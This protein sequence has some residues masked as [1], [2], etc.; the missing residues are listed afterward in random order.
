MYKFIS[1]RN[2]RED[3]T[4]CEEEC[5]NIEEECIAFRSLFQRQLRFGPETFMLNKEQKFIV[6]KYIIFYE[7]TCISH[8]I[9]L[10]QS[11]EIKGQ[12]VEERGGGEI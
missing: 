12:A 10:L 8:K 4:F 2:N 9:L 7:I 5:D 6:V 11:D 3:T 1:Y